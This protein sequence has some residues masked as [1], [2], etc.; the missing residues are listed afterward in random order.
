MREVTD[1]GNSP[2]N[3]FSDKKSSLSAARFE[4]SGT[5]PEKRLRLRLRTRSSVSEASEA[6]DPVSSR[7]SRTS[8]VTRFPTQETPV[9]LHGSVVEFHEKSL[10]VESAA[11][12]KFRRASESE[13]EEEERKKQRRSRERSKD[14]FSIVVPTNLQVDKR[15]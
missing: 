3:L 15:R 6:I 5:G 14:R 9:H 2:E 7:L 8:R 10:P 4:R 1:G 12:L 13:L 11:D